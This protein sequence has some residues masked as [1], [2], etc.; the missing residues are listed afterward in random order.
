MVA[1]GLTVAAPMRA[2]GALIGLGP[3]QFSA[4]FP[5]H[6]AVDRAMNVVQVGNSLLRA[7]QGPLEGAALG[8]LF[9]SVTPEIA[10]EYDA[11]LA[12]R[13]QFF[14]LEHLATGLKLRGA[15]S[16]VEAPGALVFLGSPWITQLAEIASRGLRFED[17]ALHDPVIDLM[18][19]LQASFRSVEEGKQLAEMLRVQTNELKTALERLR[20]QEAEASKLAL[21]A[22]RTD[23]AVI[24]TDPEG[25]IEWVNPGFTR[26]TGYALAEV[27]GRTPGS[28]LQGP[29]TDPA[30]VRRIS[31]RLHRGEG[32]REKILNYRK[33]GEAYWLALEVQ[34]ILGADGRIAN[35]MAIESD[36]STEVAAQEHQ[37]LQLSIS[38]LLVEAP[39]PRAGV[40]AT[41]GLFCARLGWELGQIWVVSGDTLQLQSACHDPASKAAGFC[42]ESRA[43]TFRAGRGLP[44]RVWETLEPVWIPD[45][46]QDA[47]FPR[48]DAARRVGLRAAFAFPVPMDG[49]LWGVCEF[50][51]PNIAQPDLALLQMCTSV[52]HQIGQFVKRCRVEEDL[53]LAMQKAEAASER[54]N[55]FVATLSHEIRTPLNAV[56]G[57]ASLLAGMPMQADQAQCV[58]TIRES[59]HQLLAIVN[60]V[61]DI[62]HL[63]SGMVHARQADFR[64]DA[65]LGH[66]M[67]IAR[68]LPGA[69]ALRID[70]EVA[71]EV[72]GHLRGDP[73]RLTQVLINL[74]GNAVKFTARGSI[75]LRVQ[76]AEAG[77]SGSW[78]AFSVLDTGRGIAPAMQEKIF[79]PFEQ[80]ASSH[81]A[82]HKGSG[83]G[84]AICRR[85]AKLL[86]GSLTLQSTE[87]LGST[88]TL[89]LPLETASAPAQAT[90]AVAVP[91]AASSGSTRLRVLVAEDTPASQLVIRLIL[92]RL[93]HSVRAVDDGEQA[94][95]AFFEE[96]F[97]LV[98]MDVQMPRMDG[99][100]AA[101][102]IR[103]RA[104][105][106]RQVP[107]VGLSAFTQ[108][109]DR[110]RALEHGMT[111][112]LAKPIV[113]EDVARILAEI[114]T[115]TGAAGAGEHAIDRQLL[116]ELCEDLSAEG[117][118]IAVGQ[119][120]RDARGTLASLRAAAHE[121]READVGKAAHRLKGLFAQFGGGSLAEIFGRIEVSPE[122]LRS[123]MALGL[124][125]EADAAVGAVQTVAAALLRETPA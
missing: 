92:E 14:L 45:V 85:I 84:L 67:R 25:R 75:T 76:P 29:G 107:I 57:M 2:N 77:G 46:T 117:F 39:S 68:G 28:V 1:E 71:P 65:V 41:I 86:G 123:A 106:D 7:C 110:R 12:K 27:A 104:G 55:V 42:V 52:G 30:V 108:E 83:L 62:S 37:S 19:V 13:E 3:E 21:I 16:P 43:F 58:D 6:L 35:F 111:H 20:L 53:R 69:G 124:G 89:R 73:E 98:F 122:G 66:V 118:E 101:Q 63:E 96:R 119:F 17:F 91:Q 54:K 47:D 88:F 24:L 33:N 112:Y 99:Y 115:E 70:T 40:D 109:P 94:L 56:V 34:P 90:P 26:I 81:E 15:F 87:G 93:G 36:V 59:S 97:D 8:T 100:L 72:P 48:A 113:V 4:A 9:R 80:G 22:S 120:E 51:S 125:S 78:L 95:Q 32:F 105:T 5:F 102:A 23:N 10:L 44:G 31:E 74:M 82:L 114:T 121:G 103:A 61:L 49:G 64:L 11:I 38:K 18:Q 79:E 50:L 60:D 116:A